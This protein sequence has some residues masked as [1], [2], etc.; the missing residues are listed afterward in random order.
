MLGMVVLGSAE[1]DQ[2]M[3]GVA[4]P[5]VTRLKR[6]A[7]RSSPMGSVVAHASEQVLAALEMNDR[8]MNVGELEERRQCD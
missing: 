8:W 2:G 4:T 3:V 7:G 5:A 1:N 6:V